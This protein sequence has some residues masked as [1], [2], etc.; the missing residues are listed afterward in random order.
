MI[1]IININENEYQYHYVAL[2][3]T[4]KC[5]GV[6]VFYVYAELYKN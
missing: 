2:H 1:T 4:K 5:V 6:E 3:A